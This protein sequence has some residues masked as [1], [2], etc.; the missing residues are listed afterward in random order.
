MKAGIGIGKFIL[1]LGLKVGL[2]AVAA[3]IVY[4]GFMAGINSFDINFRARE[5]FAKRAT[6][7]LQPNTAEQSREMI[8]RLY[9][10]SYML[11]SGLDDYLITAT[12]GVDSFYER[13]DVGLVVVWDHMDEVVVEVTDIISTVRV[14]DGMTQELSDTID[15]MTSGVY[16]VKFVRTE[17][18]WLIDDIVLKEV[19]EVEY[20]LEP[21]PTPTPEPTQI[22]EGEED[23]SAEDEA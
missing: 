17:A 8:S 4:Q 13:T 15:A 18:G 14:I 12:D 11:E 1:Y 19:I 7:M 20:D 23:E 21:V 2:V 10:D 6:I 16:D 5:A 3:V 9:T 22:P